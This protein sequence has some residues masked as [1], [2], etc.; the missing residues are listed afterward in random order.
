[1]RARNDDVN[2]RTAQSPITARFLFRPLV[3]VFWASPQLVRC[4]WNMLH[5]TETIMT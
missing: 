5:T 3:P 2:R 4:R 1:V